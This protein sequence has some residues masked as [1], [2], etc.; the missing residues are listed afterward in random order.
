MAK[1]IKNTT[2]TDIKVGTGDVIPAYGQIT[3]DSGNYIFWAY[4]IIDSSALQNFI[5]TDI[6]VVNDGINDLIPARGKDYLEYPDWAFNVRFLGDT[7]RS[8][9]FPDNLSVQEAIEWAKSGAITNDLDK[10]QFG[11]Q[12]QSSSNVYLLTINNLVAYDS[13]DILKYDIIFRGFSCSV[14][15]D[16]DGGDEAP[17]TLKLW[18][19]NANHSTRTEI[20]SETFSVSNGNFTGHSGYTLEDLSISVDKGEGLYVQVTNVGNPKPS[21]LNV[22]VWTRQ[23]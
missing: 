2:D 8:N 1:I 17:F 10:L 20:Y 18:K 13:P 16:L 14:S 21:N 11:R 22:L 19:I 12:G 5:D 23:R 9:G 15:N 3:I 7:H 4:E 6:L